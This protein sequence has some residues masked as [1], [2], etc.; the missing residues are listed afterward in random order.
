MANT[1][2]DC[3]KLYSIIAGPDLTEASRL[4]WYQ[5]KV[6][7]PKRSIKTISGLKVGVDY[8]WNSI[9]DADILKRFNE[10]ISKLKHDGAEIVKITIQICS[11]VFLT[12]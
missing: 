2:V 3:A 4:S 5:P 10:C 7:I 8:D 11:H 1:M 9:T 6:T 12:F